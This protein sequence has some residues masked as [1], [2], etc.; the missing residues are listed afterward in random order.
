MK[1]DD[2]PEIQDL[3]PR[4]QAMLY[5]WQG[6]RLTYISRLLGVRPNTLYSWKRRDKW[7]DV[8]PLQRAE[9][10]TSE[11]Y[12]RLMAKPST[13]TD[14]DMK[15][16]DAL[17]RQMERQS[18]IRKH[19]GTGK[20]SDLNPNVERRHGGK[21]QAP[22][23]NAY[24]EAQLEKLQTVFF[25]SIY[26]YQKRWYT[27]GNNPDCRIRNILKSRQIGA[28]WYFAREALLDAMITGRTQIFLSASKSQAHVFKNYIIQFA[29]EA[30]LELRGDP[31]R[32]PNGAQLHFLGTSSRTAQSYTGNLYFDEYFWVPKFQ[33]LRKVASGMAMQGPFRQT[34]FSTPS[35]LTHEAYSFWSGEAYNAGRPKDERI[36]LD[37]SPASLVDF[38]ECPD[39]QLRQVVTIENAIARGFNRADIE[40]LRREYPPEEFRNLLMCEFIDDS[41]SVFPFEELRRCMVDAWEEWPDYQPLLLRPFMYR[42]VWV[43]YDPNGGGEGGDSAGCVV[44][45]PP[46]VPGGLFR[47]LERHRWPGDDYEGQAAAIRGITE[48]YNVERI[49]I[50]STG[51]GNAVWQLVSKFFPAAMRIQYSLEVKTN[52]VLK[53][54]NVIRHGRLAFDAGHTDI[55]QSFMAIR[56]VM[57]SSG[58]QATYAASRS[59]AVGHA[60]L[61]WAVMHVLFNEPLEGN[62]DNNSFRFEV[63]G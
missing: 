26:D 57:T 55:A 12:C 43:G 39:A 4:R 14:S 35:T 29:L 10:T 21:R 9:L 60:D 5:Y 31:M 3:D 32:L 13:L 46:S 52:M 34:Y 42:P 51:I 19:D 28:T 22:R 59:A 62:T 8:S 1:T 48:R 54:R 40:Q 27:A 36:E 38:R 63:I 17:S 6:F 56:K 7:D 58:R 30:E 41:T 23:V 44:M 49:A 11:R 45:S 16:V 24:T 18:R 20:E 25:E 2:T 61:A 50:D 15:E 37:V 47:V 33:T 53:A